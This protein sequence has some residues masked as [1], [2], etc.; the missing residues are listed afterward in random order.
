[1]ELNESYF[2]KTKTDNWYKF[3]DKLLCIFEE[4]QVY[5]S[6][7]EF[8]YPLKHIKTIKQWEDLHVTLTGKKI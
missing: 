6:D 2:D 3:S 5:I 8:N 1:M 7:G 4:G